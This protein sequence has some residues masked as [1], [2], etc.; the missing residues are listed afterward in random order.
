MAERAHNQRVSNN[1][2]VPDPIEEQL[3]VFAYGTLRN[4]EPNYV[5]YLKGQTSKEEPATLAGA[6]MYDAGPFP[7]VDYDPTNPFPDSRVVGELMHLPAATYREVLARLDELEGYQPG[8]PGNHYERIA[9][10]VRRGDGTSVR[11]WIY[12][13]NPS[14]RDSLAGL[15]W[16]ES[17]DWVAYRAG[18]APR[19]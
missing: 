9:T 14:R 6:R 12:V 11:A 1:R 17:G 4:G 13:I 15:T 8:S 7:Y 18:R 3:P 19:P 10:D 16:I 2:A 5:R